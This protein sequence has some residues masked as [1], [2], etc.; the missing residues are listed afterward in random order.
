MQ[1]S[2]HNRDA[3]SVLG[4]PLCQIFSGGTSSLN[5]KLQKLASERELAPRCWGPVTASLYR[6]ELLAV[7]GPSDVACRHHGNR[8]RE[9]EEREVQGSREADA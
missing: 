3:L 5:P 1:D 4:L 7:S 8:N 2:R 9:A 6:C